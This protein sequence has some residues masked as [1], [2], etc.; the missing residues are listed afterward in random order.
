MLTRAVKVE[1]QN[2]QNKCI[3]LSGTPESLNWIRLA[4]GVLAPLARDLNEQEAYQVASVGLLV[5]EA[6]EFNGLGW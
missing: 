1:G 5:I 4:P 6:C 2:E 3:T